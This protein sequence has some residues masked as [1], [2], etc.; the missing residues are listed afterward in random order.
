[1]EFGALGRLVV[2]HL[3][4]GVMFQKIGSAMNAKEFVGL[5]KSEKE[6]QLKLYLSIDG[7]SEVSS[8][9]EK[10]NLSETQMNQLANI[11][12]DVLTDTYTTMLC[13]LDGSAS[14]GGNQQEY[15]IHDENGIPI[16]SCGDIEAEAYEQFHE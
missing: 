15:S 9:I 4:P 12:D 6:E 3:M 10:M 13:G 8:K 7:E 11:L 5:W 2:A 16:E 14:I 1:M